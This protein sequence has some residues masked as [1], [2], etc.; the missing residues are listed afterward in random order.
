MI[1]ALVAFESVACF[2]SGGCLVWFGN[3]FVSLS[4]I[5]Y[6]VRKSEGRAEGTHGWFRIGGLFVGCCVFDVGVVCHAALLCCF[7][8]F[9]HVSCRCCLMMLFS[10]LLGVWGCCRSCCLLSLSIACFPL[11]LPA[12]I[13]V[14]VVMQ[15]TLPPLLDPMR[16]RACKHDG[17][18]VV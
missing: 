4:L 15:S 9:P 6:R 8:C 13:R 17:A 3:S 7:F 18:I 14:W 11:L 16:A 10:L 1:Y 12:G 2:F 5:F